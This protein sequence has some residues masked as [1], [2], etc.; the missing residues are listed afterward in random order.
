MPHGLGELIAP[1]TDAKLNKERNI[2]EVTKRNDHNKT[3]WSCNGEWEDGVFIKGT[4]NIGSQEIVS[5][6]VEDITPSEK[7]A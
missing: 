5:K 2:I 6:Y 7:V 3:P 4:Y 1:P